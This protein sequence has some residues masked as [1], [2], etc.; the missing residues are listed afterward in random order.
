MVVVV[1]LL[2][3]PG[4][5]VVDDVDGDVPLDAVFMTGAMS[6]LV[7]IE[8][9]GALSVGNAPLWPNPGS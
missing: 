9:P 3:P 2:V 5:V 8:K 4:A 7:V 6:P 1:E